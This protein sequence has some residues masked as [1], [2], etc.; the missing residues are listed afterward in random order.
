MNKGFN[1]W[2][3]MWPIQQ[4]ER[5]RWVQST[6]SGNIWQSMESSQLSAKTV[7]YTMT[8]PLVTDYSRVTEK[9]LVNKGN[10]L[11]EFGDVDKAENCYLQAIRLNTDY[12]EAHFKL[13]NLLLKTNRPSAAEACYQEALK[14]DPGFV[15]AHYNLGNTFRRQGRLAEAERSY[16][17]ALEIDP[18]YTNADINLGVA[19]ADAG[20]FEEAEACYRR[21][22]TLFPADAMT[23]NNL[24]IALKGQGLLAKAEQFCRLAIE[25]KPDYADA[26]NTLGA[27][28]KEQGQLTGAENAYRR[29]LAIKA[30]YAE[31]LNNL[32]V[33]FRAQQRTDEAEEFCRKAILINPDYSNAYITLSNVLTEQGRFVEAEETCRKSLTLNPNRAETHNCLAGALISQGKTSE[34]IAAFQRA[35]ELKPDYSQA[36]SNLLFTLNYLSTLSPTERLQAAKAFGKSIANKVGARFSSWSCQPNPQR[37]RVG[38]ISGDL[39]NHV[40]G[41]FLESILS[42]INPTRIELIA[43]PTKHVTDETSARLK[44]FMSE[45]KP[46]FDIRDEVSAQLIHNDRLHILLDLSGHTS[47]NRLPIFAWKPAPVQATWLGYFA[48]TGV[49]EIDYLLADRAGVPEKNR[50]QFSES[51]YYLPDTRL[52]FTPPQGNILPKE[53][54]ACVNGYITF[55]CF[56]NLSKLNDDVLQLWGRILAL[57]PNTKLYIQSPQLDAPVARERLIGRL[58]RHGILAERVTLRG[59]LEREDYLAAYANVDVLLDTFPYPGGTTTCEALWMGVPTLTLAGDTLLERQ[60]ASLL[61]AA[62]LADWVASNKNHYVEKAIALTSDIPSLAKLRKLLRKQVFES[63]LFDAPR[64]ARNLEN[65]L[66]DMWTRYEARE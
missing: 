31:A 36:H 66:W 17:K 63:P 8:E 43:Y 50:D 29:A 16:R 40:V 47:D 58:G 65:A 51:V 23:L 48:T 33:V 5:F 60:G 41:F 49:A 11:F 28:L 34:A 57:R 6:E 24:A 26:Y 44:G 62:G 61:A 59:L 25:F 32:A 20:R 42:Q 2:L 15:K 4:V 12:A 38:L 55:G 27:T 35:L 45:W 54:P 64:F 9:D 10:Q 21:V 46:I 30:D 7:T 18:N 22:L 19:L 14:C 53:P 1:P 13:G 52:C 39:R 3:A 56:Q 37:L